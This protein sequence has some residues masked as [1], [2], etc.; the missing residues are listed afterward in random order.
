M[1][2]EI[3]KKEVIDSFA[4][5]KKLA[6]QREALE[7]YGANANGGDKLFNLLAGFYDT[8]KTVYE[9]V[10]ITEASSYDDLINLS[11][12]NKN[13]LN[14]E[15]SAGR[16]AQK[17]KD[18]KPSMVMADAED[19]GIT[20][21]FSKERKAQPAKP[22]V[23]EGAMYT[24]TKVLGG[25][26]GGE[27]FID[28]LFGQLR[29]LNAANEA[30]QARNRASGLS[31]ADL[32]A[33]D[34][35]IAGLNFTAEKL[36]RQVAEILEAGVRVCDSTVD[37]GEVSE[38]V[39]DKLL[40][41][42]VI[43][44]F[45]KT[46]LQ[47][48]H[49]HIEEVAK[50]AREITKLIKNDSEIKNVSDVVNEVNSSIIGVRNES[51]ELKNQLAI[52]KELTLD[53]H[54]SINAKYGRVDEK[55][56]SIE[57]LSSQLI[58]LLNTQASE[59]GEEVQKK[60]QEILS[61]Q[62]GTNTKIAELTEEQRKTGEKVDAVDVKVENVISGQNVAN[63]K[64]EEIRKILTEEGFKVT[65]KSINSFGGIVELQHN[66]DRAFVV[67]MAKIYNETLEV[68][69]EGKYRLDSKKVVDGINE[70]RENHKSFNEAV[71]E[72][73]ISEAMAD[74]QKF[75]RPSKKTLTAIIALGLVAA[76]ASAGGIAGIVDLANG[77]GG[78]S[79]TSG[80]YQ[81][82]EDLENE[83]YSYFSLQSQNLSSASTQSQNSDFGE[84][85]SKIEVDG[86]IIT[87]PAYGDSHA[88]NYD[89][90]NVKDKK[91]YTTEI[92]AQ[93]KNVEN[94]M[95]N[96]QLL[97]DAFSKDDVDGKQ[98]TTAAMEYLYNLME[99]QEVHSPEEIEN[100]K[101]YALIHTKLVTDYEKINGEGSSKDKSD[102]EMLIALEN[103]GAPTEDYTQQINEAYDAQF[104]DKEGYNP[105]ATPVEKLEALRDMIQES[106]DKDVVENSEAYKKL[107]A[108]LKAEYKELY[109]DAAD[110]TIN[111]PQTL[112]N[113][114]QAKKQENIINS[115][116]NEFEQ[117]YG[118]GSAADIND[119][120]ELIEGIHDAFAESGEYIS[121]VNSL[122]TSI[123]GNDATNVSAAEKVDAITNYI[124]GLEASAEKS[125]AQRL[126]ISKDLCEVFGIT[127]TE[128]ATANLTVIYAILGR[129]YEED[130]NVNGDEPSIT[131]NG[132]EYNFVG[133][134]QL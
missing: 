131:I 52:V 95:E 125:E 75:K 113:A 127:A 102:I 84:F 46:F 55:L 86:A 81:S 12:E 100:A 26:G 65:D 24:F 29:L 83:Q 32:A 4:L 18:A 40:Q 37:A 53:L 63:D 110:E 88:K 64:L 77:D 89:I 129:T 124:K 67:E 61:E 35:S 133:G 120:N 128:D 80:Y 48:I 34:K 111:D 119:A 70:I 79:S 68:I 25:K 123:T 92:A 87:I 101:L 45:N 16:K 13:I 1:G 10:G 8:A 74:S 109:G 20:Y 51:A 90:S 107:L 72:R 19:R 132:V 71:K 36:T 41:S 60:L 21:G 103:S 42:N 49:L 108:E 82:Y 56:S 98:N 96:L 97:I 43:E 105:D 11:E 94:N 126:K 30:E 2:K 15:F 99:N 66:A 54:K 28:S 27:L 23:P 115:L 106:H 134:P 57:K 104:K 93:Y 116:K 3:L 38:A 22:E 76:V 118:E 31:D 85:V 130:S 117:I 122:Y 6:E 33:I 44:T 69:K 91:S 62:Y 73:T 14:A 47:A 58:T 114:I 112:I 59:N 9:K 78:S 5:L 50:S 17:A 39:V 121:F 7:Q